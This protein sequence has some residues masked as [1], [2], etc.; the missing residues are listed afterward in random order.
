M[1]ATGGL[2]YPVGLPFV[3][4]A[5]GIVVV[6]RESEVPFDLRGK[7]RFLQTKRTLSK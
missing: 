3:L 6:D 7:L 4:L 2:R 1:N 5:T